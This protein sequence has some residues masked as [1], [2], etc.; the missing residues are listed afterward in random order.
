MG[1]RSVPRDPADARRP[2]AGQA[3]HHFEPVPDEFVVALAGVWEYQARKDPRPHRQRLAEVAR[4]WM[5]YRALDA[6]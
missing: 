5:A 1:R 6:W 3:E 4:R 2:L